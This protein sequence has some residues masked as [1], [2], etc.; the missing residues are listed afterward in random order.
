MLPKKP[1]CCHPLVAQY[2]E[3][4]QGRDVIKS[5]EEGVKLK[6]TPLRL[7][8]LAFGS[9]IFTNQVFAQTE[10]SPLSI[11]VLKEMSV[12][13]LMNIE[14]TSVSRQKSSIG[15][16][17]AAIHVIGQEDIRRSGVTALAE[18]FRRV[19]GMNVAR[20]DN[21]KWAVSARGFNQRFVD[22]MLVK[23]DG[24]TVYNP[25]FSGVYWDALDY[26]LEDIERIEIIRGPG[27]SVW[28]A[29][30]DNGIINIITKSAQE[31]QGGMA[32]AGA[33]TEE[34]GSGTFRYGGKTGGGA[35]YRVYG[36]GFG[37]DKQFSSS[38]DAH[39]AWS[40]TSSGMRLDWEGG[41][42]D[43]FTLQGDV[44]RSVAQRKDLRPAPAAPFVLA[45][46]EDEITQ[47]A[48]ILTRWHHR[49]GAE[50]SWEL[51]TYWD[52]VE[53]KGTNGY[54]D[55]RWD[56]FDMDFQYQFPLEERHKIV[57]GAGYRAI[58]AYLGPSTSD[59]GFAVSFPP[60]RR[61]I[62]LFNL[63]VQDQIA[64]AKEALNL[65]LG[66]KFEH[67]DFT[68]FEYQ[69]TARLLWTPARQQT[70]WASIS[71]A[72]RTPN[73]SED[74]IGTRQLPVFPPALGGAPVF[75]RLKTSPNFA[76]EE[77]L[78]YEL[79]YRAETDHQLSIDI[80]LFNNI[81][82]KLRVV[83]PGAATP[84]AIPGTFDLPL[85]FDNRMKGRTHGIELATTW[86]PVARWR[87]YGAYTWLNMHLEAD[88]ALPVATRAS[89]E[90]IQAQ[91]PRQQIY[92]QASW[93][94]VHHIDVDLTAR[95]VD[96]LPGF[97][98]EVKRYAALDARLSW[99]PRNNVEISLV[100]QNLF[101]SHHPEFGTAPLLQSLQ[102]EA[103]RSIFGKIV[104][105]F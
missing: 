14:V 84:G 3:C 94:P 102:V 34:R 56:T 75:P 101:S 50:S 60:P 93:N 66:S 98:P 49:T 91:S 105:Y 7:I 51:Q 8:L 40:G 42:Q 95:M 79:G 43:A 59:N 46:I 20:I 64:L 72:V 39:D 89:A 13:Q 90:A 62:Q 27:A 19:P 57:Y 58:S 18:L 96:R 104:W 6:M 54:V 88:P 31:T 85:T 87:L 2:R 12:E 47:G 48:N 69:P 15:Q 9:G 97:N 55:L 83:V 67:N 74:G 21:N 52:H 44:I 16:S 70:A 99:R 1:D 81:Y 23:I 68:G 10:Q 92:V 86:Q 71:R 29:N 32:V 80:A 103:E 30:A 41:G 65:T 63:F 11:G 53:R 24:R 28:G 76:S 25:L 4:G 22:K 17:P 36:K 82:D 61:H 100:G 78:A 37:R 45:N 35:Y 73:L 38:G 26:P 33:G 5:A 77:L